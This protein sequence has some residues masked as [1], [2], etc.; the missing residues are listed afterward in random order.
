MRPSQ[1]RR[2]RAFRSPTAL[3]ELTCVRRGLACAAALARESSL[4]FRLSRVS[5]Q[6]D[7]CSLPAVREREARQRRQEA[8][9]THAHRTT[10]PR[11]GSGG[12]C[13][14]A[15]ATAQQQQSRW[16]LR[17]PRCIAHPRDVDR[18][19]GH[20]NDET[21]ASLT[22]LLTRSPVLS[23][24]LGSSAPSS[25]PRSWRPAAALTPPPPPRR[26]RPVN[27]TRRANALAATL[28]VKVAFIVTRTLAR[29]CIRAPMENAKG[30]AYPPPLR[31]HPALEIYWSA[32]TPCR[33]CSRRFCRCIAL[34]RQLQRRLLVRGPSSGLVAA[35]V[36][37]PS[38]HGSGS[39]CGRLQIAKEREAEVSRA[40]R[41]A[42]RPSN[43]AASSSSLHPIRVAHFAVLC[44]WSGAPR[45]L[46]LLQLP[47][48]LRLVLPCPLRS[49][50]RVQRLRSRRSTLQRPVTPQRAP[51]G[52]IESRRITSA[53]GPH[54]R[55][56]A[57]CWCALAVALS[58]SSFSAPAM[59][60]V[61]SGSIL[62]PHFR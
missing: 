50:M 17:P 38:R 45:L 8:G 34:H 39:R 61:P 7:H 54:F 51:R 12:V 24:P 55:S 62:R 30:E 28:R 41:A 29:F 52:E 11:C 4:A 3:S 26:G 47:S 31:I 1:K 10:A 19:I 59:V 35:A 9:G 33:D 14:S 25:H 27:D 15:R 49:P 23:C 58:L 16:I 46:P 32:V 43:P 6:S 2:P 18:R 56:P 57:A 37:R 44:R 20:S 36:P 40:S 60:A 21:S 13:V 5:P 53:A 42:R 48:S 22:S